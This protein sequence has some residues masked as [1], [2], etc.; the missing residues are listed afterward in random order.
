MAL[1]LES[2]NLVWQRAKVALQALD[3]KQVFVDQFKGLKEYIQATKGN[4]NLQFVAISNLTIDAVI[5][6]VA[7]TFYGVYF[8]KQ[9]TATAA[10][11]KLNDSATAAGGASGAAMTDTVELNAAKLEASLLEPTGRAMASGIAAASETTGAGGT[12]TT[13]GDGPNGFVI[14]GA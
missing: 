10:Y 7:C 9:N 6:D 1:T 4:I 2:Q 8:K 13:T 11:A 12:D 14:L 5:A 3:A